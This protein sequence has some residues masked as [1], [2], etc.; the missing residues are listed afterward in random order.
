MI[1]NRKTFLQRWLNKLF[2]PPTESSD[3]REWKQKLFRDRLIVSFWIFLPCIIA[4]AI[5]DFVYIYDPENSRRFIENVG[6]EKLEIYRAR[7]IYPYSIIALNWIVC[8]YRFRK[9]R[10]K[11]YTTAI[12]LAL[13]WSQTLYS[14][15][16][17][18][19]IGEPSLG[20][21]FHWGLIFLGVG[22]L[23]PV[24][25][26]LHLVTQLSLIIYYFVIMPIVGQ[27][28][29]TE[30][31]MS[32]VFDPDRTVPFLLACSVSIIAISM[33]ERLQQRQFES[34]RELKVFLHSVTHDLRT[35][36]MAGSMVLRNILQQPG[37]KLTL[38]RSVLERLYQGSDRA[39]KMIDSVIE[40][41]HTEVNG[42]VINRQSCS[43]KH[44]VDSALIDLQPILIEHQAIVDSRLADNLP[45]IK[46]DPI[47]L[48][49]VLNNLIDNALKHNRD[50]ICITIDAVVEPGWLYCTVS[51][52]GIGIPK[53]HCDR[54]FQL[55]SRG[56]RS[57]YM[58]GLGI[59][60]YLSQQIIMAHGGE[61]GVVSSVGSGSTFWFTLPCQL[62]QL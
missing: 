39:Y 44:L 22:F 8:W 1:G 55:Y 53:E 59:G 6:R 41:H 28:G 31:D 5:K 36:V 21:I 40:A 49:R 18:T 25:W 51:D 26:R 17:G 24:R 3:Y 45:D 34:Q 12:F 13:V 42:V 52:D 10:F 46:A 33:Y 14:P 9:D 48:W 19:F 47:Q 54:L 2:H 16:I 58:P 37:N 15:I 7:T 32:R 50:R 35:P 23:I 62:E 4:F 38:D 30:V 27:L 60:L 20:D 56:K 61:I 29:L 43:I 11:H 57:R